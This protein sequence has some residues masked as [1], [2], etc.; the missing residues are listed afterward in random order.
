MD[1]GQDHPHLAVWPQ[2]C[3]L[4]PSQHL[5]LQCVTATAHLMRLHSISVAG[6]AGLAQK[7]LL[8]VAA[9]RVT[10]GLPRR[11][12]YQ[13]LPPDSIDTGSLHLAQTPLGQGSAGSRSAVMSAKQGMVHTAALQLVTKH[14]TKSRERGRTPNSPHL[15]KT[16]WVFHK[17]S[18]D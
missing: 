8:V 18:G 14:T 11:Q 5:P 7:C 3:N 13:L 12:G 16:E 9:V 17:Y 1:R 6:G 10:T 15:P 4:P 2:S